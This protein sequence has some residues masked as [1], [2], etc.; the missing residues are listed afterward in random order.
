MNPT[1]TRNGKIP[2]QTDYYWNQQTKTF[3]TKFGSFELNFVNFYDSNIIC[4]SD[5]S[6]MTDFNCVVRCGHFCDINSF[7][8]STIICGGGCNIICDDNCIIR[9]CHSTMILPGN[10]CFAYYDDGDDL[11]RTYNLTPNE[12]QIIHQNGEIEQVKEIEYL[13]LSYQENVFSCSLKHNMKIRFY[14]DDISNEEL[15]NAILEDNHS[16]I[17]MLQNENNNKFIKHYL[18][19]FKKVN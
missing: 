11:K 8:N 2:N 12:F 3:S 16:K 14:I 19:T 9:L 5:C 17:L 4:G 18:K 15:M 7:I 13:T 1:I 10:D 6:I